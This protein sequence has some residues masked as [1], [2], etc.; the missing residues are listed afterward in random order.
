[1]E[2]EKQHPSI[3]IFLNRDAKEYKT[4]GRYQT[5]EQ[6][7]YVDYLVKDTLVRL[8]IPF[9]EFSFFDEE[10]IFNHINN[11]IDK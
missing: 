10:G 2:Y 11:H 1:M 8:D 7:K 3:N 6:A 5:E 9:T 4:E